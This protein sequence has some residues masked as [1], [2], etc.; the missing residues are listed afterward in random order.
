MTESRLSDR[1][2]ELGADYRRVTAKLRRL[3]DVIREMEAVPLKGADAALLAKYR[4]SRARL[5]LER[6]SIGFEMV[7]HNRGQDFDGLVTALSDDMRDRVRDAGAGT[8]AEATAQR[9]E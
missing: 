7:A 1:C 4:A 5:E 9:D 2:A 3:D 8:I 6:A